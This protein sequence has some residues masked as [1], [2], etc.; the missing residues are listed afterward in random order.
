[1]VAYHITKKDY[2]EGSTYSVEDYNGFSTYHMSLSNNQRG[3]NDAIDGCRPEGFPSRK[4]C[5]YAF[6]NIENCLGFVDS[7]KDYKLYQVEINTEIPHSMYLVDF[8]NRHNYLLQA[9]AYVYWDQ[10]YA[11]NCQVK[12]YI[13]TEIRILSRIDLPHNN[14]IQKCIL[15]MRFNYDRDLCTGLCRNLGLSIVS[16]Q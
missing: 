1:M 11:E 14:S 7:I 15:N 3:I 10:T 8:L 12:E 6:D 16:T 9:L 2:M 13:G 4:K 5:Y